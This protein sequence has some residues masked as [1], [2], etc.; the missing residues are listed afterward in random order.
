LIIFDDFI[1]NYINGL[2][3]MP[4]GKVSGRS[5]FFADCIC[6]GDNAVV[7]SIKIKASYLKDNTV[8]T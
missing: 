2:N 5:L 1:R 4:V 3:H 6:R 7:L 8:G